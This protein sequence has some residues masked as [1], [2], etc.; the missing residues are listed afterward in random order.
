M[1]RAERH[2]LKD[3]ELARSVAIARDVVGRNRSR[4][5]T[6][7]VVGIVAAAA[8]IGYTVWRQ[9][10]TSQAAAMLAQAVAVLEAPVIAAEPGSATASTPGSYPTEKAK[11]EAALAKLMAAADAYPRTRPGIE[12][13][14][15][16]ASVLA[17]LGRYTEAEQRYR[18]VMERGGGI[19]RNVAQLGVAE[20]QTRAGKYDEAIRTWRELSTQKDGDIPV[21][22]VLMQLGRAYQLAGK[23]N[24]AQQTFKQ[25]VNEFPQSPYATE[26]RKELD[27]N[28]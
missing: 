27:A 6:F 4:L 25:L 7:V 20:V 2:H 3:N 15:Q 5:T 10:A 13:R 26:A 8:I 18:E 9:R 11:L 16:A 12:A 14:Y 24:E 19:Y 28:P 1:K 21:D 23:K 17:S 22:G